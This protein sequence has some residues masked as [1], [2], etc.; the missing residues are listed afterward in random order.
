ML[1]TVSRNERFHEAQVEI[2]QS[3]TRSLAQATRALLQPKPDIGKPD[4][5]NQ[6]Q[7]QAQLCGGTTRMHFQE[8]FHVLSDHRRQFFDLE[9][10]HI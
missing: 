1:G 3:I 10:G 8:I 2:L 7:F 4:V 6:S 5:A 9:G